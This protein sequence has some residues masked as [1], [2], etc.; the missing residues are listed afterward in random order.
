MHRIIVMLTISLAFASTLFAGQ[1][2][3]MPLLVIGASFENG[4][5]PINDALTAPFGGVAVN[6]G[7]YLSLGDALVRTERLNGMVINEA[8]G[9]ATT[10]DRAACLS[11]SCLPIYWQGYEKQLQKAL[12]RVAAPDPANQQQ[13]LYY[14]AKYLV[15]GTANDCL[16]ADAFGVPQG[17]STP[18]GTAELNAYVDRLLAVGRKAQALGITPVYYAYPKYEDLNLP[19]AKQLY[20]MSW[21]MDEQSFNEMRDLHRTRLANELPGALVVDAWK[22]FEHIGDGLH[23]KPKSTIAAA[24]RIADAIN[25]HMKHGK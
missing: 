2:S 6:L 1:S 16:H 14:N 12:M 21:V 11:D 23:P 22:H 24:K 10:F 13:P 15:I 20:S 7:S 18:C 19:L 5:T 4:K 17:E 3:D 8:Q 9:G 25:N